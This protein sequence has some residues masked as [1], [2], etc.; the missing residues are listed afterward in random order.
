M[1]STAEMFDTA[2]VHTRT[3]APIQEV[4]AHHRE[5]VLRHLMALDERDRFLRFGYLA[6]DAQ[7]IRYVEGLDFERDEVVGVYDED[8]ELVAMAHLAYSKDGQGRV[9]AEFG[10]SVNKGQ[11]GRGLGRQLFDH[12]VLHCRNRNMHMLFIHALTENTAM[13][14]IARKAGAQIERFGTE[15][16][17]VLQLSQPSVASLVEEML[18]AGVARADYQFKKHVREYCRFIDV[19]SHART[20]QRNGARQRVC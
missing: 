9:Q 16:E 10:G 14:R 13:L 17:A 2:V 15:S 18:D 1:N 20:P 11:R 8:L 4:P 3:P 6:S 5:R 12:A 19:L 7:V